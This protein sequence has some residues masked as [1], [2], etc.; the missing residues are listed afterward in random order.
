ML[1][2][3]PLPPFERLHELL[4]VIEIPEDKFGIWS[5]LFWKVSRRGKAKAGS[6]AGTM[7]PNNTNSDRVDWMVRV[8][9]VTYVASRVIYYMTCGED[10]GDIRAVDHRA[11]IGR[12]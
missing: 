1:N 7:Q 4:E 12:V 6:V 5:G 11:V 2:Y 8:D 9:N 10:P 3:R